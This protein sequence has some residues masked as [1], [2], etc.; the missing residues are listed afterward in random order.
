MFEDTLGQTLAVCIVPGFFSESK[1]LVSHLAVD[2]GLSSLIIGYL[3]QGQ[4]H[5][6]E[7]LI[8]LL[9]EAYSLSV[10]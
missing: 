1:Q 5:F 9:V 2:T 6:Q 7:E 10:R 4:A 3:F 8:E